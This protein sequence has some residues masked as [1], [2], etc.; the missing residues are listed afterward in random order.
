MAKESPDNYGHKDEFSNE[1]TADEYDEDDTDETQSN[2][3]RVVELWSR[4]RKCSP[5]LVRHN[6]SDIQKML[7]QH[8]GFLRDVTANRDA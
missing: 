2:E 8:N 6:V 4:Q 5:A 7:M 3:D 1:D